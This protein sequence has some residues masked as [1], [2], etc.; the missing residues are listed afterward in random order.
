MT[1]G[2]STVPNVYSPTQ[3]TIGYSIGV[4]KMY[5]RTNETNEKTRA[6]NV[7]VLSLVKY[8]MW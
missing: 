4:G 6:F 1:A 3:N 7:P 5:I 8:I 2:P